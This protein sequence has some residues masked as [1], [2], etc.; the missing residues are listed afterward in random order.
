MRATK[1]TL[2][3]NQKGMVSI[4]VTMIIMIVLSLIV[5]G[6]AKLTR[7]NQQQALDRELNTQALYAARSGINDATQAIQ[8][9]FTGDK[10]K[11]DDPSEPGVPASLT[12]S[13]QLNTGNSQIS[14][15]C[16]LITQNVKD[17]EYSSIKTDTSTVIPIIPADGSTVT[18]VQLSWEDTT[19]GSNFSGCPTS[20]FPPT[21]SYSNCDAGILRV[22]IVPTDPAH[23]DRNSLIKNNFTIFLK[24][25]NSGTTSFPYAPGLGSSGRVVSFFCSTANTPKY[26]NATISSLG[27][28]NSNQFYMRVKSLYT[29]STLTVCSPL[30]GA[31]AKGLKGQAIIDATG[32]SQDVLKR[33]Q[34]R[35]RTNDLTGQFPEFPVE[36]SA[37]SCKIFAV[38]P[39]SS[40]VP[41]GSYGS[42]SA[43]QLN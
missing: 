28:M 27:S 10:T 31:S 26:C 34:V 36:A 30:C 9:G 20:Q 21:S 6:F 39:P 3:R 18:D 1:P 42:N 35:L 37:T 32:K 17:L 15:S 24:P 5:I 8:A 13:T 4:I 29:A 43:C 11:C 25:S 19:G 16:L 7:R 2:R 38:V 12:N 33:V 41:Y 23:L 14:Y 22:D 40:V